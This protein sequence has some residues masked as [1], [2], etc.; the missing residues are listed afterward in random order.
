MVNR[1]QHS[2]SGICFQ[3][4]D[5][6]FTKFEGFSLMLLD[7]SNESWCRSRQQSEGGNV[8]ECLHNRNE[9]VLERRRE[10]GG[11]TKV[12]SNPWQKYLVPQTCDRQ[13]T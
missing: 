2:F 13:L 5:D 11:V 9:R 7:I 1:L 3:E 12:V 6:T 8:S 10:M 4:D